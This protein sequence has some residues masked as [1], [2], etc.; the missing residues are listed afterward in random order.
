MFNLASNFNGDMSGWQLPL[1]TS[2]EVSHVSG[3]WLRDRSP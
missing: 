1:L 3:F 2:M